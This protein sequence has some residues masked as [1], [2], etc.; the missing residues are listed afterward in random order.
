MF[1]SN[2]KN[3]DVLWMV[4][5]GTTAT[6]R[7]LWILS[8]NDLK[9]LKWIGLNLLHDGVNFEQPE[10]FIKNKNMFYYGAILAKTNAEN[11]MF[12]LNDDF[13]VPDID[14]FQKVPF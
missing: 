11:M 12:V 6:E 9:A 7:Y 4:T 3:L 13:D 5:K 2:Y 14:N 8:L 1:D 10:L